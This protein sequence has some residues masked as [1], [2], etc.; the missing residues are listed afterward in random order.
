DACLASSHLLFSS[1]LLLF[2]FSRSDAPR[3]LPSFPTRRSSDLARDRGIRRR[4]VPG[5]VERV[6][7]RPAA[8][9]GDG[10]LKPGNV[11]RPERADRSEEHTS[12]LQ[13]RFDLV[14]RLLL[15]KKK[16]IEKQ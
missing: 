16:R 12:E 15:E 8:S 7:G 3:D 1:L 4:A 9:S 14:C 11:R 5:L 13:S 10:W 6:D 2:F